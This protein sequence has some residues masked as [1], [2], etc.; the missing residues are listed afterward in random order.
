MTTT[1]FQLNEIFQIN[2][3]WYFYDETWSNTHGP[4]TSFEETK[5][6]LIAYINYLEGLSY[7]Y[8]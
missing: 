6:A 4:Y 2:D 7:G 5:E 1:T 3:L 8:S